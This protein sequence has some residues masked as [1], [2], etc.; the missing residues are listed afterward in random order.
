MLKMKVARFF[1]FLTGVL[2]LSTGHGDKNEE[3]FPAVEQ[4]LQQIQAG[5]I[6][7]LFDAINSYGASENGDL[8]NAVKS[9][10]SPSF[11]R[12][13]LTGVIPNVRTNQGAVDFVQLML[14]AFPDLNL[15]IQDIF[16]THD[17][18]TVRYLMSGTH[19]G[20]FMGIAPT[21]KSIRINGINIYRFENGRV[22]E[23]WQLADAHSLMQ[24]LKDDRRQ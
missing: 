17:K 14:G 7:R 20:A 21:S 19:K 15:L 12:H 8:Q 13:D 5:K 10:A 22:Q 23:S 18:V 4:S 11:L 24:Q 2:F 9:L 3:I 6:R 16:S 1:L